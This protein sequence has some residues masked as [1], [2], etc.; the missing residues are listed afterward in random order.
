MTALRRHTPEPWLAES[1]EGGRIEIV[2]RH[3][4]EVEPDG[5]VRS[6][7]LAVVRGGLQGQTGPNARL[8]AAAPLLARAC[9]L[10]LRAL[11]ATSARDKDYSLEL[12]ELQ[13]ALGAADIVGVSGCDRFLSACED[14]P[15]LIQELLTGDL[16]VGG[17]PTPAEDRDGAAGGG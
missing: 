12:G 14:S 4:F 2:S 17:N 1:G 6:L 9:C 7:L 3:L 10:C 13:A 8:L 11:R 15:R 5:S 16:H